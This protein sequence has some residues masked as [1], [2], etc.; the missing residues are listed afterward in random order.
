MSLRLLHDTDIAMQGDDFSV[1]V[2]DQLVDGSMLKSTSMVSSGLRHPL[3]F[4]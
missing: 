4:D 2:K 1:N 3:E